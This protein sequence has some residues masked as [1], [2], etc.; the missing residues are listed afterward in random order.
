VQ[1]QVQD[2]IEKPIAFTSRQLNK[3]EKVYSASEQ[4]W[5]PWYGG[6][7]CTEDNSWLEQIMQPHH[8]CTSLLTTKA[9]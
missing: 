6:A 5:W 8:G 2:G 9:D 3:S 4:K 7:I 1:S